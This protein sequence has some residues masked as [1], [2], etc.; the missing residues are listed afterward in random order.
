MWGATA[1]V[2]RRPPRSA[3][4]LLVGL[5]LLCGCHRFGGGSA[6]RSSLR[7]TGVSR[8]SAWHRR[9]HSGIPPVQRLGDWRGISAFAKVHRKAMATR[10]RGAYLADACV[11]AS[12]QGRPPAGHHPAKPPRKAVPIAESPASSRRRRPAPE[13]PGA[14]AQRHRSTAFSS[15]PWT[16]PVSTSVPVRWSRAHQAVRCNLGLPPPACPAIRS[17]G[18]RLRATGWRGGRVGCAASVSPGLLPSC[19]GRTACARSPCV[20]QGHGTP[21]PGLADLL[22]IGPLT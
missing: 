15:P 20:S 10:Y 4:P 2:E 22:R 16:I 21:S 7:R 14:R 18:D 3:R 1:L 19:A 8:S 13:R 12:G 5:P 11:R 17:L 6:A 9:T